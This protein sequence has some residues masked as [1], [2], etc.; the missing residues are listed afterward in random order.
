MCNTYLIFTASS[1]PI[2]RWEFNLL[3]EF[4]LWKFVSTLK[5]YNQFLFCIG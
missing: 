1:S 3:S 4:V 2:N 5:E